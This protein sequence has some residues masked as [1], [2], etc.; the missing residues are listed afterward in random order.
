MNNPFGHE[1]GL[2]S[3]M[4]PRLKA[5]V[6][7]QLLKDLKYYY[8]YSSELR[9]DW[10]NSCIEGK[11]MN[12]LDGSLDRFSEISIYDDKNEIVADGWMDFEFNEVT[13]RLIVYW[14]FIDIYLSQ[15][16]IRTIENDEMP[17]RLITD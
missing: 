5:E 12:Y 9:F 10:S 11:C 14:R 8:E 3:T 7:R 6:E 17:K 1:M 2:A 16:N 4:G 13:N 15:N